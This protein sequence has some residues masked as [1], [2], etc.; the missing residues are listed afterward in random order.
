MPFYAMA[1]A[2][3]TE[4]GCL[5]KCVRKLQD[6]EILFVTTDNLHS[7]GEAWVCKAGGTNA[8]GFPVPE[9]YQQAF[10]QSM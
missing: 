10:I 8:D 7:D 1:G 3:V 9:M 4:A 6:T 2:S 5:F